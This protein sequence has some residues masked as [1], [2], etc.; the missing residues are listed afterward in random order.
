[1]IKYKKNCT[2]CNAIKENHKIADRLYETTAYD[3]TSSVS[4][5][6]FAQQYK[7]SYPPLLNHVKKH[8]AINAED[9]SQKHLQQIVKKAEQQAVLRKIES[10]DIWQNVMDLG[11]KEL[12]DGNIKLKVSDM[13]RAAKDK[14]DYD[15]KVKDQELAMIEMVYHF[16]SGANQ[17][18]GIGKVREAR[19]IIEGETVPDTNP[20]EELAGDTG[21]GENRPSGV[22]YPP[23]WDAATFGASQVSEGD[24]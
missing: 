11:A 4:L 6:M 10:T 15:L 19:P 18:R 5:A 2:I 23:S 12:K 24:F 13:L 1:M 22:Y 21:E 3:K 17:E 14:A 7:L 16:A 8:Q 9:L 20:T